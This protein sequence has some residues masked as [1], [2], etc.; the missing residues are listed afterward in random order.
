[1]KA[2][3]TTAP[4]HIARDTQRYCL[5][6]LPLTVQAASDALAARVD[7]FLQPFAA[8][9][10]GTAEFQVSISHGADDCEHLQGLRCVWRQRLPGGIDASGWSGRDTRVLCLHDKGLLIVDP[11]ARSA[12]VMVRP[13]Q[14]SC[15]VLGLLI[16]AIT[17]FL[18]QLGQ[19]A[20][21]AACLRLSPT[22]SRCVLIFGESGAGKTTTSLA[23]HGQGL[24]LMADDCTILVP[25]AGQQ[26]GKPRLWGLPRP[27]KVHRRTFE[28][29]RWLRQAVPEPR[30]VSEESVIPFPQ[31]APVDVQGMAEP[32]MILF[33]QPRN[34]DNHR[35]EQLK[36]LQTVAELTRRIVRSPDRDGIA[37]ANCGFGSAVQLAEAC[38]AFRLSV[39]P[40]LESLSQRI[41]A[42]AEADS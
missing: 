22:S 7:Q 31:L 35:L 26:H 27:C 36:P 15:L 6:R 24:R 12:K 29:V 13:G 19:H 23:L 10:G 28:M 38:P 14:E 21:H 25:G 1:M 5:H 39:G 42:A 34:S 37:Q 2:L 9:G 16:P 20:C 40:Q 33:L 4:A 30:F 41:L 17:E 11:A 32:A 3:Q 8:K 18:S